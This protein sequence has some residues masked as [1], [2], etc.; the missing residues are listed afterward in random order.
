MHKIIGY[1]LHNRLITALVLIFII[2]GGLSTVPFNWHSGLIPRNPVAVDAIPNIGDN[3]QIIATDWMGRSPKD[4]QEQVTYPLTTALLGIPGVK[5][6]RSTSMFGMSFI[7]IIFNDGVD[8]YWSRSRILEKLN[9]LPAGLLPEGV[10]PTL[11]PDATALGQIYWYTLEG[12]NP[13]TGKPAGGWDPQEL[14]TIQDYYV[15]YQLSS[16]EGVSEVASVGGYVKEYQVDLNPEA[17]RAYGLNLVQVMSAVKN[18]NIDVGA[19]TMEVNRAEYLIRGL[20]YVKKLKDL[21]EAAITDRHGVAVRVKDVAKVSFGPGDR[22]GGLDKEGQE[23]VG[24]VV[25]ARNGSNPMEVINNVKAKIAEMQG[26]LPEKTLKDGSKSRVTVVPFYDRSRL[27]KETIGTLESSLIHEILICIIV[28]LILVLNLRASFV[29]ATML[30]LAVL[31]TFIIMKLL[32]IEANIVALSGI[33]IAIGVMVD[34][35]VVF[36]ENVVRH[37]STAPNARG[38]QLEAL[39]LNAVHE[40]SGAVMTGMATTIISFLP[41]FAMQAQEG[42]MFHPLAFTKTFA[43]LSALLLG[44]LILPTLAYWIFS[45]RIP[46]QWALKIFKKR[47][48][49]TFK[50]MHWTISTNMLIIAIVVLLATYELSSAWLPLGPQNGMLLNLLFVIVTVGAILSILWLLVLKY[51][52]ILRWCLN[53][54]WKFMSIPILTLIAGGMIWTKTGSEFM[55][56]LDEGTFML[57][58]TSLPHSGVEKNIQNCKILDQRIKAI[59]EVESVVGKWGRVESALDPAPIQMYEITINYKPEYQLDDDGKRIRD[60]NG[61]Y[62]RLWRDEIKNEDDIWKEIDKAANLPGLTG[63]PKLQPI[64]TRQVMLSTG[65]KAPMGLKIYGPDLAS[66]EQAGF[67]MEKALKAIPD[68]NPSSVYYDRAEGAPYIEIHLDREKLGR[69]GIQVGTVQSVIETAIGGMAEG[70]TVEGRERFPIRVRYAR[71][72]RDDPDVLNGILVPTAEGTQIPLGELA[73]FQFVK[74][75]TMIQSENTFLMGYVTFDKMG[76]KAEVDVVQAAQ[77][78]IDELVAHGKIKLS[79]GVTYKFTGTYEQQIHAAKRLQVVI[80]IALILIFLVLF[81]QFKSVTAS[82]IHFSGVFVAFAGGFIL[83]WLYG[84]E[85]FFNFNIAG[86][87]MRTL[88]GMG[89]INLSVA[90]WVGFIALFGVATD[91]GVL[92]GTYIHQVFLKR[93]PNSPLEIRE[94]VVEA[95]TK[96]VRP[97]AMTTATVLIALLPVLSSTGKGSDIMVPMSIPTFGGMLIQTMTMFVVPVFQCWWRESALK[98]EQKKSMIA[99]KNEYEE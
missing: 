41:V 38:K 89:Q 95:G 86:V 33:A 63:S 24:G 27:I 82:M 22:R 2:I 48:P 45:L 39:I 19:G 67:Q 58:P 28:V 83:I 12:R 10:R 13:K 25:V 69:Y 1:F 15:R 62:I 51:E 3:Q 65:M 52:Q 99:N 20:G 57:M 32:G 49:R 17:M 79:K 91:D 73:T 7:Y 30:P 56:T 5:T 72:L 61:D 97:A 37:L 59:P 98:R 88:F 66:I 87:N 55:P 84:Q 74:G 23:A 11:G 77:K 47:V 81:F 35:G 6:I 9:S 53:N 75:A 64:A 18:S 71:E 42:R 60:K 93:Q 80:P 26:G 76:N 40:L 16:A 50:I 43:L 96:R 36:M 31:T 54:R 44:I 70:S 94:A 68:I 8:F 78:R 34:V 85:W 21:E 46:K 92:M 14:R 29:I 4:I 90:V